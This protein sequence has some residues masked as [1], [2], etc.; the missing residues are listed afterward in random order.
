MSRC[1]ESLRIVVGIAMDRHEEVGIVPFGDIGPFLEFHKYIGTSGVNYLDIGIFSLY[2]V[3]EK[4]CDLQ[5]YMLFSSG[6]R[7]SRRTRV[8]STMSRVDDYGVKTQI[9]TRLLREMMIMLKYLTLK[10][11]LTS[12]FG[13]N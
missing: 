6:L 9:I 4:F 13:N 2:L 7:L 10:A 11:I 3:S 5:D 1:S 12:Q 8:L